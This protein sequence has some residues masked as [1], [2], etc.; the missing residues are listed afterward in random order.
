[1]QIDSIMETGAYGP[2]TQSARVEIY[3]TFAKYLV[4]RGLAYPCF[5]SEGELSNLRKEQEAQHAKPGYYGPWAKWR[6]AT[7]DQVKAQLDQGLRP[8][9][10][11]RAPYPTEERV[12][13]HDLIKGDLDLP[14][15]DQD[16]VLMKSDTPSLPTYHFA[17][18][19]DDTLMQVN[20]VIRGDEWLPSAPLHIQLFQYLELPLPDFAHVAPIA[21]MEGTSKRKL[22]KRKDPE[23]NM[24]YYYEAGYPS[25]AVIEY[26]LNLANSDFYDWRKANPTR[27]NTEFV[28]KLENMGVL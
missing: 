10:R 2:Y 16:V 21:K 20:T 28:L 1:M 11:V 8:V 3:E 27:P 5:C 12:R 14:V 22:S 18:V 6:N 7:F 13:F 15:N 24:M 17:H 25:Q 9:I 4:A 26:L 23:A 19:V